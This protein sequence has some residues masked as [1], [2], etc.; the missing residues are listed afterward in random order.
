[1]HVRL[2]WHSEE[3]ICDRGLENLTSRTL[4]FTNTHYFVHHSTDYFRHEGTM[5]ATVAGVYM[6][7]GR[8]HNIWLYNSLTRAPQDARLPRIGPLF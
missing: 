7:L 8:Y 6:Q 1:M 5:S 2:E 3:K 4:F